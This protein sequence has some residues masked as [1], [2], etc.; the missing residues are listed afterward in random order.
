[1]G[2]RPETGL[3][4]DG[5]HLTHRM[6]R[7]D[8]TNPFLQIK[9]TSMI[10]GKS[11]GQNKTRRVTFS[12]KA[13]RAKEVILVG[14]FNHWEAGI[15]RLERGQDGLWKATVQLT[16]GSH[17]FKFL[18]DGRWREGSKK[19]MTVRNSY[20]TLNNVIFVPEP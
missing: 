6:G 12:L 7:S 16:P 15:H 14:D 9:G 20:G 4:K 11:K 2:F 17:E 1:L 8:H 10:E 19:E 3:G 5:T 18:V 13:P